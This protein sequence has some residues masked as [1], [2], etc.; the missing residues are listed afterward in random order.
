MAEDKTVSSSEQY[1]KKSNRL[2][3]WVGLGLLMLS[4]VA[5]CSMM[6]SSGQ[7]GSVDTPLDTRSDNDPILG[8]VG[9][10]FETF[11]DGTAQLVAEPAS[12][13]MDNVVLGSQ[14]EAV[15]VLTA[16]NAPV[17]FLGQELA[18]QQEDGFTFSGTCQ[19]N[20]HIA[21]NESCSLKVLWN[22]TALRQLQNTLMIRWREDSPTVYKDMS[23]TISLTGQST[24]SK[25]CVICESKCDDKSAEV[26]RQA[27]LFSGETGDVYT[28]E[29]GQERVKINGKEYLV[30]EGLLFDPETGAIVGI[31]EPERIPM[32]L[33]NRILGT[34][35]KTQDV[36]SVDGKQL[37]RLLGDGTIVDSTLKVVGAAIP[38]VSVMDD[39]GKII[40][41]M[42]KDGTVVDGTGAIIGMPHVDGDV[43]DLE[44]K[45]IGSLRPYGLVIGLTGDVLG[46]VV[47][48]GTVVNADLQVIGS[49]K[50]NGFAVSP[51]GEILGGVVPQGIAVGVGCKALGAVQQNGQVKDEFSQIVGKVL[52]DGTVVDSQNL[53]LGSVVSAGLV[54]D[55][56]GG[57]IGFVNSEGKAIDSKGAIIGC[58]NPDG[59]VSAGKRMLGA[60]MPKGR[61]VGSGCQV[62]GSVYP[63]GGVMNAAVEM[64]GQVRPDTYVYNSNNRIVGVV[65]PRGAAIA[66][67]C[68][69]LGLISRDGQVLDSAG[70]AVGCVNLEKQVV[71]NQQEVIGFIAPKGIVADKNGKVIGRVRLDGKVMDLTGKII[72]CV[73]AD[74]TVVGLD[75]KTIIGQV[76]GGGAGAASGQTA[77]GVILDANGDPTGWTVIGNDVYDEH[78]NKIGTLQPNG[79]VTNDRGEIIGVIPPDG[80]IVSHDGLILGRYS[81]Q[82]GKALTL[83]G[84]P[85][86]YVLPDFSVVN[87]AKDAVIGMLIPD[88]TPF[89]DSEN[90]Y[91]G[92]MNIEGLL[93]SASGDVLGAIKADGTVINRAGQ[94]IGT[95][96]PQG[97]VLSVTGAVVG[98]ISQKGEVLSPTQSVIGRV[99]GNGLAL[100]TDGQI[101]GGVF[102]EISLPVG[103]DGILGALTY[104][105][106]I[107]DAKGRQIAVVSPFGT[108]YGEK[109]NITGRLVRI[110][111]YV[112][113]NGKLIGWTNFKGDITNRDGT[114]IGT[115]TM[116]GIALNNDGDV[117]G[118]LVPRGVLTGPDGLYLGA[119]SPNGQ[120]LTSDGKNVGTM[121]VSDYLANAKDGVVGQLLP[122][123]V[124]LKPE[125]GLLGWTR[126]DGAVEN[127]TQVVGHVTFGG[128][129][130]Q[131]GGT[132]IG[133]YVP[134][135]TPVLGD[136]GRMLGLVG[137]AGQVVSQRDAVVGSVMNGTYVA[138]K[139]QITGRLMAWTHATTADTTGAF[140][141]YA[142]ADGAVISA[143]NNKPLG[144]MMLNGFVSD[145]SKKITGGLAPTGLPIATR[146]TV[147]GTDSK[148]GQVFTNGKMM[149][150]GLGTGSQAVYDKDGAL[151][152]GIL[153]PT[154]FIE[155]NGAMIGT[156]SGTAVIQDKDGRKLASYMAFGSALTPDTIWAG[157]A[158]PVGKAINDDG[159]DIGV[160]AA[161]GAVVNAD[162]AVMGRILP[163]GSASGVVERLTFTTMP[164]IG[165]TVKQGLP[166]GYKNTIL[167]RTTVNGDIIDVADKK[168]YRALDDGTILGTDMPLD[169]IILSF[170]P[171]TSHA[172]QTLGVL[173]GAGEVMSF[174]GDEAGKIAVNGSV[175]G[176]HKY[177]ILGAL[178]PEP[179]VVNDCKVVGQT[180]YNGQVIDGQGRATGRILPDKWA[181][182]SADNKIGRVVRVGLV[183]SPTGDYLGRT[184][185]DS[186]VVD[187][188]GVNMGCAKNDGSVVDANGN[189]I[190]HVIER[191]LVV[192]ENGNP[193]G[194]I[195][196]DGTVVDKNGTVIGKVLGDGKGTVVDNEGNV[197]GRNITPDEEIMFNPDGTI[198]G[199]F[200]RNG[201]FKDPKGIEQFQVLPNGDIIDPKTGR[202]IGTLTEDGRLL[203]ING[204]EVSDIRVLRDADGNYIGLVDD[205][206]NIIG[207]DGQIIGKLLP[208][209]TIVDVN[210]NPIGVVDSTGAVRFNDGT[211]GTLTGDMKGVAPNATQ[212]QSGSGSGGR[213]IYIGDKVF[214][215]TPQGSL[216]DKDGNIIG[217]MGEDGRPYSLDNRLLVGGDK[218]GRTVPDVKQKTRITPEQ[219]AAMDELLSSRRQAMKEKIHSFSRLLPDGRTLAKARKKEDIDWGE[220]KVVSTY[221]VDM[222]RMILK[223]KAI[224]AVL[225]HSID[226]RYS[227][228]PV[229]AIVERHIYAEQGRRIIIPAGSRLIGTMGGNGGGGGSHTEK[230]SIS[231]TRL[232]RPDGSAF[233][234]SGTSGDA[235]GRGGVP[236]Y[237]DEQ[238]LKK[239]GKP[240]LTTTLTSAIAFISATNDDITT[241]DNGD[242]VQSSR[243][244]AANDARS[245]FIDSMSDIFQQL[246]DEAVKVDEV[247]F[248]PAGTRLTVYSNE[249]LWLRSEVE[250]EQ[251]YDA[252]FGADSKQAKGT[253]K[254][255]WIAGR[256]PELEEQA[257][258][259]GIGV[260]SSVGTSE[261]VY[262]EDDYYNPEVDDE[263]AALYDGQTTGTEGKTGT[264]GTGNKTGSVK[265]NTNTQ[266]TQPIFPTSAQQ[267]RKL[268]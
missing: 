213:R 216:V 236:A 254:G 151:V 233:K 5:Y 42:Q 199:T 176:N 246:L 188:N 164:Y 22:P 257:S 11:G 240:V 249:D 163:D 124:A 186:T 15:V 267:S 187:L 195:R 17:L 27:S 54:I 255:N 184:M 55:D 194:R 1:T 49:I 251:D 211:T 141:G 105:G 18:E 212:S 215:V 40:G 204:N 220:P 117:I 43:A 34:I 192:D 206:G 29:N 132:V 101:L 56:R 58:V 146:L 77:G 109:E 221:P 144:S 106:G 89:M 3:L 202:K 145:L 205:E 150:S 74:G 175:K 239:Y 113:L 230:V 10:G 71:D 46:G 250:D 161:D 62:V 45:M 158:M 100:T 231:W 25:G 182:D 9:S 243:S 133:H 248:V 207:P 167:G 38:I 86:G 130:V 265:G 123:G 127:G 26:A 147:L 47:P 226:S 6:G 44:G 23:T 61:V 258:G 264:T 128:Q 179:L 59:T 171:A 80:V 81:K 152:G 210:G 63:N 30:K 73:N 79:W 238:L 134:L 84:E 114:V 2:I 262:S 242:Q 85:L 222:S 75:G 193:I 119:V 201:M 65:V 111:P 214:E 252:R 125:G 39:Q 82:S 160:V 41:K 247:L 99:L 143:R 50:P 57:L 72:G 166:F 88:K 68:R 122:I 218:D 48:D 234:F 209:G 180:S 137:A 126:Y 139:G 135:A 170:N 165:H 244:E 118:S 241:K 169:G 66:D 263:S 155:K 14:A 64:I 196:H 219:S 191:G 177:R 92:T 21:Q 35:T 178:V 67:G 232:I 261:E 190:G 168:A 36:L 136:K 93:L 229:T 260:G 103:A 256:T 96:I 76:V 32:S 181:V 28:D 4:L 203:D 98:T 225:V 91:M 266:M 162:N 208:D 52:L 19:P 131:A 24:D 51:D 69:M 173:D 129:V 268:F 223:D 60:V 174:S 224:P 13:R 189:E 120:I 116:S 153:R 20:M 87:G 227:S 95:R 198:A 108:V 154:V 235:Q 253:S 70:L 121:S 78:G 12:V 16:K 90:A 112:D 140:I 259:A 183:A 237:L 104:Q 200:G 94:V 107:N 97:T 115:V 197:I 7:R 110:G 142:G 185:P 149:G 245:N 37:G 138:G 33:D 157:N 217:Y 53:D 172:G 8:G 83:A 31:V 102:P 228:T 148:L 159:Y 156:S